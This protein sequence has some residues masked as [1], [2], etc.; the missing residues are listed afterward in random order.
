MQVTTGSLNA[1]T[2]SD[3]TFSFAKAGTVDNRVILKFEKTGYFTLF[4]S[5]AL[6]SELNFEA[7]L[8][9]QGNSDISLQTTFDAS[10]AKTLQIGGMKIDFPAS[11]II[12]ADGKAYSGN[13]HANVL[14]LA[15]DTTNENLSLMMT[16]GDLLCL[17]T[18]NK[19]KFLAALGM[20]NVVL[21]DNNG[22]PLN[23]KD[24]SGVKISFPTPSSD[25]NLPTTIPLWTFDET[26]GITVEDGSATLQGS[27]YTGAVNH[28]STFYLG[29]DVDCF[30]LTIHAIAC[31]HP[32]ANALFT[33]IIYKVVNGH[34][35]DYWL[36]QSLV[37]T[38]SQGICKLLLPIDD[39]YLFWVR[40]L[41]KGEK[42][43]GDLSHAY[44]FWKDT[45]A[46]LYFD[47]MC[48]ISVYVDACGD[49]K[50]GVKVWIVNNEGKEVYSGITD[51]GGNCHTNQTWNDQ[52]ITVY[53]TYNGK[54]KSVVITASNYDQQQT[55]F[56][57]D[58][59][60]GAAGQVVFNGKTYPLAES[61]VSIHDGT[62][63]GV[64]FQSANGNT[65]LVLSMATPA[66]NGSLAA[67]TYTEP[68]GGITM[69]GVFTVDDDTSPLQ[70][71]NGGIVENVKM[72]V[73][74]SGGTYNITVTGTVPTVSP[75]PPN[76]L[77]GPSY[78]YTLT[79]SGA[80]KVVNY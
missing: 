77:Y 23:I 15:P 43:E 66:S 30:Y 45:G 80:L 70:L 5:T 56:S 10:T 47:K 39:S 27:T 9:P 68:D 1:T 65:S 28:F 29:E 20:V 25:S 14:Y 16:G 32:A 24:K 61:Q 17:T 55:T 79:Y 6:D 50:E 75:T 49:P 13:V 57:F 26:K 8:Y 41:Y 73:T 38:N 64:S 33:G 51:A 74:G 37:S 21:A 4:R 69:F 62:V 42:M 76:P 52:D 59:A 18:D 54:T 78:S 63:Y 12:S 58:D 7:M 34:E 22:N 46:D 48:D 36:P 19:E 3:G 72:D 31:Q 40:G 60:C 44:N 2:G 35:T 53:A 11:S 71:F 67:R